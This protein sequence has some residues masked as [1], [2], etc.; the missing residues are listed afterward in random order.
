MKTS[1]EDKWTIGCFLDTFQFIV[2]LHG[3]VIIAE[4]GTAAEIQPGGI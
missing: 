2:V 3:F 4:C 1:T